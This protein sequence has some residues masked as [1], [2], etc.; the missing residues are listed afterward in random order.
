MSF[1][2]EHYADPADFLRVARPFLSDRRHETIRGL[3]WGL[4]NMNRRWPA[5]HGVTARTWTLHDAEDAV[6]GAFFWTPP[7]SVMLTDLP[8]GS[9]AHVLNALA[10]VLSSAAD[11]RAPGWHGPERSVAIVS[12]AWTGPLVETLRFLLYRCDGVTRSPDVDGRLRLATLD[13]LVLCDEWGHAFMTETGLGEAHRPPP[14][15]R[16]NVESERL[17]LWE[18]NGEPTA[19]ALWSRPTRRSASIG[20]VFVPPERR[21]RG[22]AGA[23][24]AAL[25]THLMTRAGKAYTTLF[26]DASN[27][28]TNHLYPSLGYALVTPYVEIGPPRDASEWVHP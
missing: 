17:F 10:P 2:V 27:P 22:Y 15:M 3:V 28:V 5:A 20:F 6:V 14:S 7:R 21:G 24:T 23:V 9:G 12:D 4:A 16:P 1:R 18:S 11:P 13:D 19:C 8:E 26:T 25:T